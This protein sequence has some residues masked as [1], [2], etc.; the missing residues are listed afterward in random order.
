MTRRLIEDNEPIPLDRCLFIN[1]AIPRVE[2]MLAQ[3]T[4]PIWQENTTGKLVIDKCP[5]D[6]P[7]PDMYDAAVLAFA[8]DSRFGL[9]MR[10]SGAWW[11]SGAKDFNPKVKEVNV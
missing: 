8:Q 6:A 10:G 11:K 4:Q 2:R 7:S 1:P 5:E 3:M 9:T